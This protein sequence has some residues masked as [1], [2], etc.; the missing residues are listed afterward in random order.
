MAPFYNEEP[1]RSIIAMEMIFNHNYVVTTLFNDTFYDH[2]PLWYIILSLSCKI[3]GMD[4]EFAFRFPSALS[5]FLT[6]LVVYFMGKKHVNHSFGVIASFL[7]LISADL[8][9][10][11][12]NTA[13][14]DIFFSLL[15]LLSMLSIYHFYEQK[16][17]TSLFLFA[18]FFCFLGFLTKGV[19]S[20]VFLAISLLVFFIQKK[21]FIKLFL[22]IH[23][24]SMFCCLGG[25]FLF[26]YIY[27]L[28][29]DPYS[30]IKGMWEITRNKSF[31]EKKN[32][33]FIFHFLWF[34][35]NM[36]ANLFPATLL[37]IFLFK[38]TVIGKI[39]RNRYMVFLIMIFFSNF[40]IY[41]LSPGA[42]SRYTYMFYPIVISILTY[43]F[44]FDNEE[45]SWK[46]NIFF[47]VLC[48]LSFT[49]GVCCFILP[50]IDY[51]KVIDGISYYSPLL[52]LLALLLFFLQLK[53]K[54]FW[55]KLIFGLTGIVLIKVMFS[56]VVYPIKQHK[57]H[58]SIFKSHA[59]NILEITGDDFIFLFSKINAF[60]PHKIGDF[61]KTAAY[62]ELFGHQFL[63]K[64]SSFQNNG[65]YILYKEE[66]KGQK[67]L[68]SIDDDK[69]LKAGKSTLKIGNIF[70]NDLLIKF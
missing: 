1:R 22:P 53:R 69:W 14:I 2:P 29:D 17:F 59:K 48:F 50:F 7:Y 28:Y 10:F 32:N 60:D 61:Y 26:F 63:R 25:I 47:N 9:F 27:G 42:K 43:A 21:E 35:I 51:F 3:F 24:L 12:S 6:G 54:Y 39:K 38:K 31:L 46:K 52:G 49:L 67:I 41:W 45:Y 57:S 70:L 62:M 40:I 44:L 37:I 11:F 16:K 4:S 68:Y 8:Y 15:V 30:Y 33:A 56:L 36:L 65:Y 23:F 64:T 13:E 34:P 55:D 58:S 19:V 66:L 5:M 20:F 18:Y